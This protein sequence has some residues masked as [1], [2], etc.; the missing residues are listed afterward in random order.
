MKSSITVLVKSAWIAKI[1][2][3]Y[4][5]TSTIII[6]G[7][8]THTVVDCWW[9]SFSSHRRSCLEQTTMP[10]HFCTVTTKL[11]GSRLKTHLFWPFLSR[12]SV[13][14]A[15]WPV[16]LL[17]FFKT[18]FTLGVVGV[19]RW[20]SEI[21][22]QISTGEKLAPGAFATLERWGPQ[23]RAH[24]WDVFSCKGAERDEGR[25]DALWLW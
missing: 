5:S 3:Y 12:L 24:I 9:L 17:R 16:S 25:A 2:R 22:R 10:G 14:P 8:Q 7:R 20:M 13:V 19:E 11:S 15:M 21:A 6:T 4:A 18:Y 23:G 1:P